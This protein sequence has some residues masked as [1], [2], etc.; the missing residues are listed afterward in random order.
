MEIS[1]G[2]VVNLVKKVTGA[3]TDTKAAPAVEEEEETKVEEAPTPTPTPT[4][5]PAPIAAPAPEP[6]VE[7]PVTEPVTEPVAEPPAPEPE[8]INPKKVVRQADPN[9]PGAAGYKKKRRTKTKTVMT[10]SS[11][12]LG[13]APVQKK[14]LLGS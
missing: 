2:A 1:M 3:V 6:V 4:P 9:A 12:V 7:P 10:S 11:G 5:T 8:V 14:T 13:E